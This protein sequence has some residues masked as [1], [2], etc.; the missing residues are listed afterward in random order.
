M[1]YLR[2][3]RELLAAQDDPRAVVLLEELP[4][5]EVHDNPEWTLESYVRARLGERLEL[6][7][8]AEQWLAWR[9]HGG[10]AAGLP[11]PQMAG[12]DEQATLVDACAAVVAGLSTPDGLARAEQWYVDRVRAHVEDHASHPVAPLPGEAREHAEVRRAAYLAERRDIL[13]RLEAEPR[14]PGYERGGQLAWR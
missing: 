5:P 8:V 7:H 2:Y 14:F 6:S 11:E 3:L 13:A 9:Y 10:A 12:D 4:E 1:L